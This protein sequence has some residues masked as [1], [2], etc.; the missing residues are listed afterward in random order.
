MFKTIA[1]LA[2]LTVVGSLL[3]ISG[4]QIA[5]G[6]GST[7]KWNGSQ[8]TSATCDTC[9]GTVNSCHCAAVR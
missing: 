4:T 1:K 8:C 9:F 6:A 5:Q 2:L 3:V 7:C